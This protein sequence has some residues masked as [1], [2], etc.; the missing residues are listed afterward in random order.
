M[1][2]FNE[3]KRRNVFKVSAAYII[4]A[5]LLMQVTDVII[6]NIEAPVWV[7]H[8]IL[9]MLAVGF[10]LTVLFAWAFEMTPEGVKKASD[11]DP[12]VS[13]T[14]S[15]GQKINYIIIGLLA[16]ALAYFVWERQQ[17]HA[18]PETVLNADTRAEAR[19]NTAAIDNPA[20]MSIAVLPF[21]DMSAEGD[22]EYFSDGIAEELLNVL[23]RVEGLKV[24]SR[25]SSFAFKGQGRNIS[26]IASE[27]GVGHI[28]EGSVRKAGNRVRVTAQLI[29]AGTD[30]HLWSET[31]DRDLVDIFAIQDDIANAIVIALKRTLGVAVE[32]ADTKAVNV[33]VA[34]EN[35]SAYDLYLKARALFIARTE[36]AESMRMFEQAVELDPDFARAWEGLAA[37]LAV[38]PSWGFDGRD[39]YSQSAAAAASAIAIEPGLSLAYAVLANN[40]S[41]KVPTDW[42]GVFE[43][44]GRAISN[45]STNATAY[46]WRGIS[47][48]QLGYLDQAMTDFE[49]CT[50]RDPAYQNC[51]LHQG[52]IHYLK[53][54][55]AIGA[56]M[57]TDT[58]LTGFKGLFDYEMNAMINSGQRLAASSWVIAWTRGVNA[59]IKEWIE[60]LENPGRDMTL[61]IAKWDAWFESQA[62]RLDDVPTLLLAFRAY[63][64]V[65]ARDSSYDI[66]SIWL[67]DNSEFRKTSYFKRYVR[68]FGMVDY[69]RAN[70]FPPQ[71]RPLGDDDFECDLVN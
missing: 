65:V 20:E 63:D 42:P 16:I 34:T 46:L 8:V 70:G 31:Y 50:A 27:L 48:M 52:A 30:R 56:Q 68:D 7:F 5:W 26:Q 53:G 55:F 57:M 37:V 49:A 1:S 21:A 15:T 25:T 29:D 36:L 9:L 41:G 13:V 22:Q 18:M 66:E 33:A 59:P 64:R 14:A 12:A 71:C 38:M 19:A 44:F 2:L 43:N 58:R 39:Y 24:A 47:L 60:A 3:L 10:P 54:E 4:V 35:I 40:V 67:A 23:V 6:N 45:D 17:P 61:T 32:T 62:L 11:V 28:I 51:Y 69:W